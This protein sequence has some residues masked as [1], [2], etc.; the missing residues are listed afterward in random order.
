MWNNVYSFYKQLIKIFTI[1]SLNKKKRLFTLD[2]SMHIN[3]H[4]FF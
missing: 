1:K 2:N 4:L 3:K